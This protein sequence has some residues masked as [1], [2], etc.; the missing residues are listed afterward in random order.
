MCGRGWLRFLSVGRGVIL[1]R[2]PVPRSNSSCDSTLFRDPSLPLGPRNAR[3]LTFTLCTHHHVASFAFLKS[4]PAGAG[5]QC[6]LLCTQGP[7]QRPLTMQ[8]CTHESTLAAFSGLQSSR[9][10]VSMALLAFTSPHMSGRGGGHMRRARA[11]PPPCSCLTC[12]T[13]VTGSPVQPRA[14]DSM[15][16]GCTVR[17]A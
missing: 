1:C 17:G 9:R 14:V 3:S 8:V 11:I 15:C 2:R 4:T 5:L 12:T 16:I 10:A 7:P 6:Q 13:R